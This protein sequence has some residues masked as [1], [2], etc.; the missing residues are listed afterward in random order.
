MSEVIEAQTPKKDQLA[1]EEV[2]N[3]ISYLER[4]PVDE[5]MRPI[6]S[7]DMLRILYLLQALAKE[8]GISP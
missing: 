4:L 2:N 3:M 8:N 7:Y 5:L 6:N 1:I